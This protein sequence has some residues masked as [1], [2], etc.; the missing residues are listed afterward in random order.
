VDYFSSYGKKNH[1]LLLISFLPLSVIIALWVDLFMVLV[2]ILLNLSTH[3][4]FISL[5]G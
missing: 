1:K 2:N 5:H 4:S 3:K